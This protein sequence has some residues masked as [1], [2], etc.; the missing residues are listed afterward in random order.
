MVE[1]LA[2]LHVE[3][4]GPE[5][6]PRARREQRVRFAERDAEGVPRVD[7]ED[8]ADHASADLHPRGRHREICQAARRVTRARED[9]V[10]DRGAHVA[11]E[12]RADIGEGAQ[13][14]EAEAGRDAARGAEQERDL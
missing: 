3:E 12:G 9:V 5:V 4:H 13:K 6:A 8:V 10:E 2:A 11:R 7:T 14:L 1:E